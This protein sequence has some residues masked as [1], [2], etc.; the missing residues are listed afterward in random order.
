MVW[1]NDRKERDAAFNELKKQI[2]VLNEQ[3]QDLQKLMNDISLEMKA[4]EYVNSLEDT[5]Q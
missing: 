5:K 3:A 2:L 4:I 1:Y